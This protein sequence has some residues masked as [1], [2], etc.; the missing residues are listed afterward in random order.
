MPVN[1]LASSS[2]DELVAARDEYRAYAAGHDD[3]LAADL[4]DVA[5]MIDAELLRRARAYDDRRAPCPEC[6]SAAELGLRN[7]Q[8]CHTCPGTGDVSAAPTRTENA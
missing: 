7:R 6:A 1:V 5:D 8:F 3:T 2:T 4:A